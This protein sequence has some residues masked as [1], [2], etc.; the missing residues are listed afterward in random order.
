[1]GGDLPN[2][3]QAIFGEVKGAHDL[4]ASSP[5]APETVLSELA[6]L[7]TDRLLPTEIPWQPYS[8]G[9]PVRGHYVV[10]RTFSVKASRGGMVQ[11]HAAIVSLECLDKTMLGG[12]LRLLPR[13]AQSPVLAPTAI[14]SS[15]LRATHDDAA[16]MPAGYPSLVRMLLDGSVPIWSGQQGF[17]DIIAYLWWNLWPEARR[18]LRFRICAEPNDLKELPA[19]LICTPIALRGNWKEQQFIDPT[20]SALQDPSLCES[21]LLGLPGGRQ[22]GDLRE[23]LGFS[24]PHIAGLK[25]LE[26]YVRMRGKVRPTASESPYGS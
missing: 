14:D 15:Q 10:T 1:M 7:Y 4:I 6:S 19:T 11:T 26:Q 21:Y 24:P 2:V 8:C 12:L 3:H 22:F 5:G 23:S 25:R 16:G 9:F 18:E 20:E 13:E 17:E